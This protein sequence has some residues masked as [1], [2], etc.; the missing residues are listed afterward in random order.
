MQSD[1]IFPSESAV[2]YILTA[3]IRRITVE[4]RILTIVVLDQRFEVL[5]FHNCVIHPDSKL[6]DSVIQ[7]ADVKR[8][9]GK[10]LA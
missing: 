7:F 3:E 4:E 9:T 10:A 6:L 2:I 5:I 1:V 8:L